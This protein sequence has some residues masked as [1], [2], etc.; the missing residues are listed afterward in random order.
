VIPEV[1][2]ERRPGD[3]PELTSNAD[4]IRDELGV[5]PKFT[6]LDEIIET[7]WRWYQQHPNGY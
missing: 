1:E 4:H 6:E 7:A 2:G 3:P 5:T